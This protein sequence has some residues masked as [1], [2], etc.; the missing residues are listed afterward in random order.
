M[1]RTDGSSNLN[2]RGCSSV[3]H[4]VGIISSLQSDLGHCLEF[5]VYAGVPCE[6]QVNQN[7]SRKNVQSFVCQ[8]EGVLHYWRT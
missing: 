8:E 2:S 3:L 6:L 4:S 7:A 5:M 1:T